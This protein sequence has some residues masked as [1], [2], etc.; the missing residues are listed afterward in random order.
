MFKKYTVLSVI[1]IV[2]FMYLVGTVLFDSDIEVVSIDNHDSLKNNIKI[3]EDNHYIEFVSDIEKLSEVRW[4]EDKS[5]VFSEQNDKENT[6]NYK[7]DYLNKKIIKINSFDGAELCKNLNGDIKFLKKI[8]DKQMFV[9]LKSKVNNGL[10]I[11]KNNKELVK[12]LG[13]MIYNDKLLFKI[14]SNNKKIAFFDRKENAIKVLNLNNKKIIK[15]DYEADKNLLENF[16]KS[17]QF[18]YDAGYLIVSYI[19]VKNISKSTFSVFG[20]DSGKLYAD[21]IMGLS[22]VWANKNLL[23]AFIYADNNAKLYKKDDTYKVM[24]NRVGI[25]NL[26]TRKIKYLDSIKREEIIAPFSWAK[27]DKFLY[28]LV[29]NVFTKEGFYKL[30]CYDRFN[31]QVYIYGDYFKGEN[32]ECFPDM[33]IINNNLVVKGKV[34]GENYLK[35]INLQNRKFENIYEVQEFLTDCIKNYSHIKSI[36][37]S[38]NDGTLFY[39]KNNLLYLYDDNLKYL[40]YR[41]RGF[42]THIIESPS[43]EEILVISKVNDKY[44]FAVLNLKDCKK[45]LKI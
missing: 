41:S 32:L 5:I 4:I 1:F 42:I 14:S 35:I 8:D 25:F 7:F 20:A 22:P 28:Y 16:T 15:L 12:I 45:Y 2:V 18:S 13:D 10:F 17:L 31:K 44:E 26:K 6:N 36:Y 29:R 11:L 33:N 3:K 39:V 43:K 23:I 38:L 40:I 24:G 27:D 34:K 19:D 30:F 21:E 37:K 9:Y